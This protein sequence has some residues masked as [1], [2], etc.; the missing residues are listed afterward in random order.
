MAAS[1]VVAGYF[2]FNPPDFAAG[3]VALAFGLAAS[4]IFP[5]LMMGIFSKNM[6]KEGAIAGMLAGIGITLL[7]VFQHKGVMFIQSTS[8]LGNME[9]NWFLG[10]EPNAF[11]A[12]GAMVNFMV[13]Y[14]VSKRMILLQKKSKKWLNGFAC[15]R[16]IVHIHTTT[17]STRSTRKTTS[18]PLFLLLL[19][20]IIIQYYRGKSFLPLPFSIH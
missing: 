13:A 14:I 2:G 10:I 12:V 6:N 4:S 5:A 16:S 18:A 17:H 19:T 7:Y 3:T 8:F 1:I 9:P 11:G 15:H 20:K